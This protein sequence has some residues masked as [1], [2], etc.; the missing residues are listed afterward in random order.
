MRTKWIALTSAALLI[1]PA[2]AQAQQASP[3]YNWSGFYLGLN[4]GGAWGRANAT[5][6]APSGDYLPAPDNTLVAAAGTGSMSGSGFTGGVQAGYNWQSN[7]IVYGVE[8]DFGAFNVGASRSGAGSL[9]GNFFAAV[10]F[11]V[12]N[13][14]DTD[15]LFTAR[16]RIGWVISNVLAYA[17]GGLA[18]TR[19]ETAN[20]HWDNV[21]P[22]PVTTNWKASDTKLGWTLGGGFEWALGNNWTVKT[23]YLYLNFGSVNS[24]GLITTGGYSQA[25]STST[26]LTAHIARAGVNF[27]F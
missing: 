15:W 3:A 18:V 5:T 9:S 14:A 27:K 21:W 22:S 6:S 7:N 19:I 25:I 1:P 23:E 13:S 20:S 26:D 2:A 17:T 11:V 12:T 8:L 10:P 4:A 24:A 16:G